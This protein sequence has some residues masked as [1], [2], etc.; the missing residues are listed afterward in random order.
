MTKDELEQ[1]L[2]GGESSTVEFKRCSDVPHT[3]TFETV[4]SFSNRMGGDIYL[5]VN[6]DGSVV[7]IDAKRAV[8]IERNV[9]NV[10]SNRKLFAPAPTVETERILYGDRVV[11]R[12]WVASGSSVVRYK[13]VVYDRVADTDVR[14]DGDMQISQ[15]YI[16]KQNYYSERRI[17]RYVTPFDLRADLITRMREMAV[18]QRAGHPWGTMSDEEL[19]RSAK[20]YD[21]DYTTGEEGFN[22]AAVLLL[23]KD[24]V[25]SSICPAYVTDAIVRRE[26]TDR[27]DDRLMVRTNLFDAYDRLTE[28]VRKQLPDRFALD[29]DKR[30]SPREVISRE[31][32][33]NSLM[34]REYSSPIVARIIMDS[35]SIR[36]INASR[37]FFEGRMRL[38]EFTPMPKNPIIADVFVQTGIAEKLG[39][40]LRSLMKASELYT[41]R[42]PEF[43]DGDVFTAM[44]PVTR[45]SESSDERRNESYAGVT[46]ENHAADAVKGEG[47]D[48]LAAAARYGA[49]YPEFAIYQ[50]LR[51]HLDAVG[52]VTVPQIVKDTGV[53]ART[54]RKRLQ[55]LVDN[56]QL[57]IE[58]KT[59]GRR[60]VA[61]KQDR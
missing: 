36:T 23:G 24:D 37:S 9:A 58:G 17:Y 38:G 49:V 6:D 54:I 21:R 28:F 12:I 46:D 10:T 45:V 61:V 60:Y 35:S 52:S 51:E 3:D 4:C 39:S 48:D 44:I 32:V 26:D 50:S 43:S 42:E 33:A 5:G 56:G 53:D 11:I 1:I 29:G 15:M 30:T 57:K 55:G 19:F 16:R 47:M 27:Y 13:G 34:H 20:L 14:I 59:R 7:G 25:I 40:G 18:A 22:L 31:L 41:G 8:E 2:R